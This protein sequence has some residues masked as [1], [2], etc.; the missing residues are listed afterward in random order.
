MAKKVTTANC[1][2]LCVDCYPIESITSVSIICNG[3]EDDVAGEILSVSEHSG[4]IEFGYVL[5][6]YTERV[7]TVTTGGFWLDDGS[8]MPASATPIPYDLV[9]AYVHQ[10]QAVCE[11]RGTFHTVSLRRA[12]QEDS[13][14]NLKS[15]TITAAAEEVLKRYLRHV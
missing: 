7:K 6:S 1:S 4:I 3:S 10:C 9:D 12:D 8:E 2:S 14:S 15:L 5:G 11:A 13:G